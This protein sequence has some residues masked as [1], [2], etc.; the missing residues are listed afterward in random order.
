MISRLG[1]VVLFLAVTMFIVST[2]WWYSFFHELLGEDFQVA[3]ECFYWTTDLCRLKEAGA[4]FADVP[5]YDPTLLWV[6]G[7]ILIVGL[8]LR[9]I[10]H[11]G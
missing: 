11:R 1:N 8:G 10:G 6:S 9:I 2:A 3:R 4:L 5:V 7:L